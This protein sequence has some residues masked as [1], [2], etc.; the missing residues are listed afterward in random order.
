M[1]AFQGLHGDGIFGHWQATST[2]YPAA[3]LS[4]NGVG[5]RSGRELAETGRNRPETITDRDAW[6]AFWPVASPV[7]DIL[8]PD[9]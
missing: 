7:A 5:C 2:G 9:A 8:Q 4:A 6:G 1:W 3:P